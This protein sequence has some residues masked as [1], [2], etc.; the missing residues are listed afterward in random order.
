MNKNI[1][2]KLFT[3]LITIGIIVANYAYGTAYAESPQLSSEERYE[4]A[5]K[6]WVNKVIEKESEGDTNVEIIDT[7]G[8][9]SRGCLQFQ[10]STWNSYTKK[11]GLSG[12][13]K[14][15]ELAKQVAIAMIQDN[16]NLWRSWYTTVIKKGVGLPPKPS[17]FL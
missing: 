7:N 5:L 9:W 14:D 16:H 8:K 12:S 10:D 1:L 4:I 2:L 13:P 11:Y 3:F 15:C 6:Q 17:D